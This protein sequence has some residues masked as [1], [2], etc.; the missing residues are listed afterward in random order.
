MKNPE[1]LFGGWELV[2]GFESKYGSLSTHTQMYDS[3]WQWTQRNSLSHTVNICVWIDMDPAFDCNQ[4][5]HKNLSN[6]YF[7]LINPTIRSGAPNKRPKTR[8][9][10]LWWSGYE[11]K[12]CVGDSFYVVSIWIET[13]TSNKK[14]RTSVSYTAIKI[15]TRALCVSY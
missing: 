9:L 10:T 3:A 6:T 7:F 2:F 15:D 14:V 13:H 8:R 1:S 5:P 11:R 12:K 4:M